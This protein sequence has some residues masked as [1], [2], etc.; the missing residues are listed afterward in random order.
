M[1]FI[2]HLEKVQSTHNHSL[3]CLLTHI[4][5]TEQTVGIAMKNSLKRQNV[6]NEE[7]KKIINIDDKRIGV[8]MPHASTVNANKKRGI[9]I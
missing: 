7:R 6:K 9:C 8:P 5:T 2:Y 1:F 3:A 4:H